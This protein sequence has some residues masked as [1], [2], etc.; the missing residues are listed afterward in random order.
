MPD[1]LPSAP[2]VLMI[3]CEKSGDLFELIALMKCADIRKVAG[4]G[5]VIRAADCDGSLAYWI[6]V[7][8]TEA[9][10]AWSEALSLTRR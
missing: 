5:G 7:E 1:D 2:G 10:D 3:W 9:K 8:P 6:N 4:D